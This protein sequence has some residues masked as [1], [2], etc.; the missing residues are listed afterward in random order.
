M[1]T[2]VLAGFPA[3]PAPDDVL[4]LTEALTG[5]VPTPEEAAAVRRLLEAP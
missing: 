1:L 4:A 5:R 3:A 2:V